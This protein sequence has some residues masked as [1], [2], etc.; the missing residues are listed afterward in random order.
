MAVRAKSESTRR[1]GVWAA[2]VPLA[3]VAGLSGLIVSAFYA[4]INP[5]IESRR[6]QEVIEMGLRSIFPDAARTTKLEGISLPQGVEEPVYEVYGPRNEALGYMYYV[7]GQGWN[8]FRLAV[9]VDAKTQQVVGVRVLEHQETPGLGS[10]I[11]EDWFLD[12]FAGKALSEPFRAGDD[13]EAIT[14]ATVSTRG[15]ATTVSQSARSLL[16]AMGIEVA[17]AGGSGPGGAS[18]AGGAG[19]DG[20]GAAAP[21]AAG[22]AVRITAPAYLARVREALGEELTV[23]PADAWRVTDESGRPVAWAVRVEEAGYGG[24]MGVLV[25][26]D[27]ATLSVRAVEVLSHNETPGLGDVVTE[28]FFLDQFV[29]RGPADA[30]EVGVDIDGVT[31][32]TYSSTAVAKAVKRAVGI[33]EALAGTGS[34]TGGA[35]R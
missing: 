32:A 28:A 10:R 11:T 22:G 5:I 2:V 24:P 25:L 17:V 29:G 16:E 9:G 19:A 7:T 26:V 14:G 20:A 18:G 12:Q 8:T 21:G 30:L 6:E 15:V 27:A 34:G 23:A 33:V 4:W 13:V 3:L 1:N 31:M 35:M